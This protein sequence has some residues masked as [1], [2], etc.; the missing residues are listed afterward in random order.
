MRRRFSTRD[1]GLDLRLLFALTLT[2]GIYAAWVVLLLALLV[3]SVQDGSGRRILA[4]LLFLAG[5]PWLLWKHY[6][7]SADD[8]LRLTRARP[9]EETDVLVPVAAK[10]A[11]QADVREPDVL[12][13]DSALPNALAI[14]TRGKPLVV[15]TKGLLELAPKE[16]EAVIAHEV[17]HIANRDGAVMTFVGGPALATAA[18][19]HESDLRGKF[20]A[21]LLSPVW[22]IGVLV[23]RAVSRY[24]E[25][26]ADRGSALLT[27]A[28]EQLMSA[29]TKIHGA[30]PH[31]DLR[32]G[33]TV[34]ALCI[35]SLG[36]AGSG[37]LSDHPPL[38]KR[39]ARL[40][41]MA[42]EQGRAVGT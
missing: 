19:W 27:G 30:T 4:S 2:L 38:R 26:A 10:L 31:G 32:G 33:P 7:D 6:A 40:E 22:L 21:V 11:A 34:S 23:M 36:D 41:A 37:L 8:A 42:R 18:L 28:P 15:V 14:P 20:A 13:A 9:E 29:L 39:L 16:I 1:L 35:R 24:R 3:S 5:T 17:T 12:L 25:Y